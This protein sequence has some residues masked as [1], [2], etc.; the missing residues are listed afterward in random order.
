MHTPHPGPEP[1]DP[2][3]EIRPPPVPPD[4]RDDIVPIE[5]P[6]EPG[7]RRDGPPIIAHFPRNVPVRASPKGVG[8]G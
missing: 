4:Q 7:R 8:A 5:E 1:S 3:E 2:A 6:P